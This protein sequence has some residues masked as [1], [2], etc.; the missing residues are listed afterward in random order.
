VGLVLALITGS[1]QARRS[2]SPVEPGLYDGPPHALA[3]PGLRTQQN[4]ASTN[5]IGG[6][7]RNRVAV[8]VVGATIGGGGAVD[9]VNRVSIEA[10]DPYGAPHIL[11]TGESGFIV[12]RAAAVRTAEVSWQ[13]GL[14]LSLFPVRRLSLPPS[15]SL[16]GRYR[17]RSGKI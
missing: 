2:E 1:S 3:L 9:G 16:L 4:D 5:L 7:S 11:V 15:P 12:C 10:S 8:G 13:I 17:H 14:P 6:Y